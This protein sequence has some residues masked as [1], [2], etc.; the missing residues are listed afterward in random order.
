MGN[1]GRERPR[2]RCKKGIRLDSQRVETR[3]E[4]AGDLM[5]LY[6]VTGGKPPHGGNVIQQPR[7]IRSQFVAPFEDFN[8]TR[9]VCT[10]YDPA[11]AGKKVMGCRRPS[12]NTPRRV[13]S[14]PS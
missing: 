12:A 10:R 11:E 14:A 6:R 1:G 7:K 5:A 9:K 4:G 8:P 2:G 3:S 13:H